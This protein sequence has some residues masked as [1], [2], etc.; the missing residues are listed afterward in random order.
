MF[1]NFLGFPGGTKGSCGGYMAD[2]VHQLQTLD[3]LSGRPRN[4]REAGEARRRKQLLYF[5]YNLF[6]QPMCHV[7]RVTV[8]SCLSVQSECCGGVTVMKQIK[9]FFFCLLRKTKTRLR[10]MNRLLAGDGY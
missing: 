8:E 9:L 4:L 2:S 10:V 6:T 1:G 5:S 7:I 3:Q